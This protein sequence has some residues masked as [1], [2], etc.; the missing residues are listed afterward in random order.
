MA[1]CARQGFL[2]KYKL[3][4]V[5]KYVC[6][7]IQKVIKLYHQIIQVYPQ[8]LVTITCCTFHL[9]APKHYK[10]TDFLFWAVTVNVKI[11]VCNIIE[12]I[13]YADLFLFWFFW[14]SSE[15]ENILKKKEDEKKIWW[16]IY[17]SII[18]N[19]VWVYWVYI[20]IQIKVWN[21][22]TEGYKH[23]HVISISLWRYRV[24]DLFPNSGYKSSY[25]F[26]DCQK[27]KN[28]ISRH[29]RSHTPSVAPHI[30]SFTGIASEITSNS[31]NPPAECI[32]QFNEALLWP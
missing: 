9:N 30:T 1:I 25:P 12:S 7:S 29:N 32:I 8:E 16:P 19:Q 21:L 18:G 27:K 2:F 17:I 23:M 5:C 24:W 3:K 6:L 31:I 22:K 11:K 13:H 26:I 4:F 20:S 15:N 14:R 28:K 10:R